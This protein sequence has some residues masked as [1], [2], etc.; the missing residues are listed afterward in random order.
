MNSSAGQLVA[1]HRTETPSTT[2]AVNASSDTHEQQQL[3]SQ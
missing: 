1:A 2:D 3:Q